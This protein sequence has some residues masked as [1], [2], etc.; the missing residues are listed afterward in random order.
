[1]IPI[2]PFRKQPVARS[3]RDLERAGV[4]TRTLTREDPSVAGALLR[5]ADEVCADL[6]T[7]GSSGREGIAARLLG[8]AEALV[9]PWGVPRP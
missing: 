6:M 8:A 3:R 4:T 9:R 2:A 5:Y 7:V 1:L